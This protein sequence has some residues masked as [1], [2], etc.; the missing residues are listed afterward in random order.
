MTLRGFGRFPDA[1]ARGAAPKRASAVRGTGG[2][3]PPPRNRHQEIS[4][5]QFLRAGP[6]VTDSDGAPRPGVNNRGEGE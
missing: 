3:R 4:E 5:A 6:P 1:A 2:P